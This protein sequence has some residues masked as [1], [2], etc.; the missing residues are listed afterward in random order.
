M[1]FFLDGEYA[2]T[3]QNNPTDPS[4]AFQYNVS[5][6][7]VAGLSSGQHQVVIIPSQNPNSSVVLFDWAE[8]M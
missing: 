2:G 7:S 8:Y 1:S 5:V 6:Y 3:Y 4:P